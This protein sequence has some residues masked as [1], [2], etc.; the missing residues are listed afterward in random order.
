[1]EFRNWQTSR[2]AKFPILEVGT[3]F[4]DYVLINVKSL[5]GKLEDMD[6]V[7]LNYW[8][9]KFIQEVANK[10]GGCYPPRTLYGIVCGIKRHLEERNGASALNPLDITDKKYVFRN[11]ALPFNVSPVSNDK[12]LIM[13]RSK[14]F[15]FIDSLFFA[16]VLMQKREMQRAAVLLFKSISQKKW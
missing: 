15:S 14:L 13:Q 1:L 10:N 9:T 6:S 16:D 11:R 8:L 5:E 12:C 2:V 3:V 4:K 7:I